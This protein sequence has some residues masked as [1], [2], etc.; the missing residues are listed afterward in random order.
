MNM[1]DIGGKILVAEDNPIVSKLLKSLL[2]DWGHSVK[3][4]SNGIDA[5]AQLDQEFFDIIILDYQMPE[6][7]GLETM[8][9][10]QTHKD[11]KIS[12]I[13]II[14]LTGEISTSKLGLFEKCGIKYFLR[15]PIQP[16]EL[17]LAIQQLLNFKE[18]KEIKGGSSTKYLNRITNNNKPLMVEIIDVFFDETPKNLHK[19]KSYC[20]S[21][22]W[23]SFKK[24]LHKIKANYSYV[25]IN[26]LEKIIYDLEL[27]AE[28]LLNIE[29]YLS[30]I[31]LMEEI[32]SRSMIDLNKKRKNLLSQ[33]ED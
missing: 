28:R 26:Q 30:K 2:Q 13:P 5:I 18:L 14:F 32:T 4:V 3:M 10:I 1:E 23:V 12:K 16:D 27:D 22:D 11:K 9:V 6:L 19:L 33:I 8:K 31:I 29:T 7:N 24:L 17:N 15:K 21:E 25:G 20:I